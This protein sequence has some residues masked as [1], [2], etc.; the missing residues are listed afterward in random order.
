MRISSTQRDQ[1]LRH[2]ILDQ[3]PQA[4]MYQ[5][6]FLFFAGVA[7]RLR[8]QFIVDIDRR[9]HA[10]TDASTVCMCQTLAQLNEIFSRQLFDQT[11]QFQLQQCG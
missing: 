5:L 2:V 6:C 1:P 11:F 9:S 4:H 3:G 8:E 10:Y 7:L